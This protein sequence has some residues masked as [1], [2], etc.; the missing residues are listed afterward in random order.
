MVP[1]ADFMRSAKAAQEVKYYMRASRPPALRI[2]ALFQKSFPACYK[3]Y[4]KVFDAGV[5]ERADPGPFLGRALVWKLQVEPHRDG[6]DAGPAV[7]FPLGSF[8]GGELYFPDLG[9]KLRCKSH[10]SNLLNFERSF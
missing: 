2:A 6:L 3:K 4:K 5:W 7:C 9:L 1:S 10:H 8:T